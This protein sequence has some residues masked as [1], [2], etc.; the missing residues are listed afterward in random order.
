MKDK[1]FYCDNKAIK[2]CN[3]CGAVMCA[4]HTFY[5]QIEDKLHGSSTLL[6]I[7]IACYEENRKEPAIDEGE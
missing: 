4:D 6:A 7:C 5:W 3:A 2:K 1:C